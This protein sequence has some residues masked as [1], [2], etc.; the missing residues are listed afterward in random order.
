MASWD[1]LEVCFEA[2]AELI[3]RVVEVLAE[4]SCHKAEPVKAV[5]HLS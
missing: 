1:N 3:L 5:M 2:E 4:W